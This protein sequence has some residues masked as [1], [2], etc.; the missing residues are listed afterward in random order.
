MIITVEVFS[1]VELIYN[2]TT[3]VTVKPGEMDDTQTI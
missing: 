3:T 2:G 1:L